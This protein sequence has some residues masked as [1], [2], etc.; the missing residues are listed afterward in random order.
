MAIEIHTLR[1]VTRTLAPILSSR[2]RI[3][4]HCARAPFVPG[5]PHPP[6]ACTRQY[7]IAGQYKTH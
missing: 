4:E 2:T 6:P 5:R 3:V 7:A 1:A